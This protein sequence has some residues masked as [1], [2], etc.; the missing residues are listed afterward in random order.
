MRLATLSEHGAANSPAARLSGE[1]LFQGA[2][3]FSFQTFEQTKFLGALADQAL[4]VLGHEALAG[5]VYKADSLVAVEGKDGNVDFGHHRGEQGA[6]LHCAQAL[7]AQEFGK[8]IDFEHQLAE[9]I[10]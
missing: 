9:S 7:L 6:G 8:S 4:R 2:G 5:T 10:P 1:N 3:G